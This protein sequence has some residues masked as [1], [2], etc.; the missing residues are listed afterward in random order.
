MAYYNRWPAYVPVAKRRENARKE[1]EKL[2]KK[3]MVIEP[4]EA[5]KGQKMARTFWGESWCKHLEKFSDYAN[6]LPRGRTYARNGSVCHLEIAKG[7]VKA[8]VSGTSLYH[9]HIKIKPLEKTRW[10]QVKKACAGQIGSMLELL[11]GRFSNHVMEIVTDPKSGLFP[12]PR[13]INLACDCPDWAALC[14]H[15]A[16]VLY[17]IGK[18][19]DEKPKLLFL[20]RGVDHEE[21]VDADLDVQ[22]ATNKKSTRRRIGDQDLGAIFDVDIDVA[23]KPK[24]RGSAPKKKAP[25]KLKGTKPKV[26]KKRAVKK[27]SVTKSRPKKATSQ[28]RRFTGTAASVKRLREHYALTTAEFARLVGVSQQSIVNWENQHGKL[29]L[30]QRSRE[31]LEKASGLTPQQVKRRLARSTI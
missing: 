11:Q 24:K 3:G 29:N 28:T 22:A 19:L 30:Q 26:V 4:V 10:N 23:P 1:M 17:G 7:E 8:I 18:R 12:S 5:F 6:R 16:A 13:E 14:K 25:T 2:R 20:L 27:R 15:L 9:I 31:A 21:L